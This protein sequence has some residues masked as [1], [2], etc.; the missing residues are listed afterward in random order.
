MEKTAQRKILLVDDEPD[1]TELLEYTFR[2]AG[3]ETCAMTDPLRVI[4]AARDFR[5]DVILL[6][7]MMPELNGLSL[8]RMLRMDA[9]LKNVP[10]LLLTARVATEDRVRGFETGADDYVPKPFDARELVLRVNAL[11]KRTTASAV[12]TATGTIF[13]AGKI[14]LDLERHEASVNGK[15]VDLTTMEFNLL[16]ILL[17]RKGRVQSRE[18][19]L[20]DVWGYSPD[21]E[22]RTVDTHIRRLREK[23]GNS[24]DTLETVRGVGY[25]IAGN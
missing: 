9:L 6:D 25:K 1:V 13:F 8:L 2:R 23:L 21:L 11:L 4:G 19:L 12:A 20:A 15:P 5:P 24:A 14:A 17:R 7:V 10:V 3:F 18:R 22:T 16:E